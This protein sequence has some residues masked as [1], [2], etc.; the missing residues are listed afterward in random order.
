MF[1]HKGLP[2]NNLE[3]RGRVQNF[4]KMALHHK[5]LRKYALKS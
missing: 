5:N 4:V 3:I 2:D 1:T